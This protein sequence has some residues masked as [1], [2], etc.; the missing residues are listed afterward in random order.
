[1]FQ[2][3]KILILGM[4]RSGYSVA[5]FLSDKN[6]EIIITDNTPQEESKLLELQSLGIQFFNVEKQEDLLDDSFDYVI[7]NP[8]VKELHP[9]VQ[10]A[11]QYNIPVI[12]ELE[13][14][15]HF[16]PLN[17]QIIGIT[18]SNG[19][20]TTTSIA[21]EILKQ[22]SKE[23][24]LA[25]NIGIPMC[26]IIKTLKPNSLLLCEIS[27][28]QLLNFQDF[29]VN[30]S[31]L[32]NVV[33]THID[34]HGDFE[35]YKNAKRKIFAHQTLEDA[36]II[37][38]ASI[39][40]LD[41]ASSCNATI[42]YFD[43]EVNFYD[44]DYIYINNEKFIARDDLVIKGDHNCENAIVAIL[45]GLKYNVDKES[46]KSVLRQFGGVEHRLEYV[47]EIK[48]AKFY[49]DSKATN[50]DSTKIALN[51]F[52]NPTILILGGEE[53]GQILEELIPYLN[54]VKHIIAIG[55]CRD[56]IE[57]F[58][59]E[60][61]IPCSN[62]EFLKDTMD[63]ILELVEEG[64]TVLFSPATGSWDQ[65]PNFE[66]RGEEFVQLVKQSK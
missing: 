37:N 64:D 50:I 66:V 16:L 43:D 41:V 48:G 47:S 27:D 55:T 1:M 53:R 44:D 33:K 32:T 4:A 59:K 46:I 22:G 65:Y 62:F 31:V 9:L 29:K 36:A 6:N 18:G 30:T 39:D 19:K 26:E 49:N 28:H 14:A 12:N 52:Q 45:I 54:H 7:K 35:T 21:Y 13:V 24:T 38:K 15:Y 23:V 34:F 2:N 58:A 8:G 63:R 10:K 51:S 25:G 40:A 42:T 20:T 17:V 3:K 11:Y 60:Q 5:K 61:S 57:Q 56:R